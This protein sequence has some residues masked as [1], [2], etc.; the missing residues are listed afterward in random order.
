M[1]N[2]RTHNSAH[3]PKDSSHHFDLQGKMPLARVPSSESKRHASRHKNT[4]LSSKHRSGH[5]SSR[6]PRAAQEAKMM[7][8]QHQQ[9]P[10]IHDSI[11]SRYRRRETKIQKGSIGSSRDTRTNN[12]HNNSRP[13]TVDLETTRGYVNTL[14]YGYAFTIF[15]FH[16]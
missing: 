2:V 10:H 7:H 4:H 5:Q 8:H 12:I 1:P 3:H 9:Q 6:L 16:S 14:L 13:G 15:V 11:S